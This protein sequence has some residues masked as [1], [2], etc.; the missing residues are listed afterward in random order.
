MVTFLLVLTCYGLSIF[1]PNIGAAMTLVG[2]TT[3]PAVSFTLFRLTISFQVGFILP[4]VYYWKCMKDVPI[5]SYEKIIAIVVGVCI[6]ATSIL[7]LINFFMTS[8]ED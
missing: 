8:A 1:I 7:S 4:I 6:I 2:S 5:C 3:N